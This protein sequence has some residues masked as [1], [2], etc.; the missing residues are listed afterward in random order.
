[1]G[2]CS[3]CGLCGGR[4]GGVR[5]SCDVV[6]A[7]AGQPNVGKSTLFNVLTGETARVA[8]WPGVTVER[9][10]G[11]REFRGKKICFIDLPGTYG[12]SASSLEEVIARE[13]IVS[14]E[15]DL[16]LVLVDSTAPERT[17]Y[18]PVQILE[19]T[20]NVIIALTKTDLAHG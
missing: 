18:L 11:V 2:R 5:E 17:L 12:I 10:E 7:V 3:N 20:P 6:V 8:N 9:K 14:G 16:I 1:M 13:Y 4:G 19:L 15:P